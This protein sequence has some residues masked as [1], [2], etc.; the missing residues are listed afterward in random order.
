LSDLGPRSQ[1]E[2]A[3]SRRPEGSL[4]EALHEFVHLLRILQAQEVAQPGQHRAT[5][6]ASRRQARAAAAFGS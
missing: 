4:G 3:R 5:M 2:V 6:W 1:R